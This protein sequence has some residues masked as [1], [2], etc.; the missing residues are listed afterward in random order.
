MLRATEKYKKGI[1]IEID[2]SRVQL[3]KPVKSDVS[4]SV[5]P[6]IHKKTDIDELDKALMRAWPFD[7]SE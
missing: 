7:R 1:K 4:F 3:A 5:D 6:G 2:R